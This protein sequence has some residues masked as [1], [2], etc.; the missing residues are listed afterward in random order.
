ML[1]ADVIVGAR[2]GSEYF[3]EDRWVE[4]ERILPTYD[5]VQNLQN[6]MVIVENGKTMMSFRRAI[7]TGD[8]NQDLNLDQCVYLLWGWGGNVSDYTTPAMFD[9]HKKDGVFP[10]QLCLQQCSGAVNVVVSLA[11]LFITMILLAF[12]I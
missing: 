2:N 3:V 8:D 4:D 11:S 5:T 9:E 12:I 6:T 7:I 10:N 1:Q